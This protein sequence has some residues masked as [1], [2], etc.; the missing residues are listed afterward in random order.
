MYYTASGIVTLCRWPSGVHRSR[1]SK[2]CALRQM[3]R[4]KIAM[5]FKVKEMNGT[6]WFGVIK[7]IKNFN[8]SREEVNQL[9][10]LNP[11]LEAYINTQ[12]KHV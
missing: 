12:K 10:N 8:P 5:E 3:G 6:Y 1:S 11:G 7:M 9:G 4:S 2:I